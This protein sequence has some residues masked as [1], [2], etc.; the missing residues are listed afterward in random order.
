MAKFCTECGSRLEDNDIFCT[1]CGTKQAPLDPIPEPITPAA[2]PTENVPPQF[3]QQAP[4]GPAPVYA[5]PRPR[6]RVNLLFVLLGVILAAVIA[7]LAIFGSAAIRSSNYEK[8]FGQHLDNRFS[9]MGFT[10]DIYRFSDNLTASYTDMQAGIMQNDVRP[11]VLSLALE[12]STEEENT[13]F[14]KTY[15]LKIG[16]ELRTIANTYADFS[17]TTKYRDPVD[18][19]VELQTAYGSFIYEQSS[20]KIYYPEAYG[21]L[22]QMAQCFDTADPAQVEKSLSGKDWLLYNN[23]AS[24]KNGTF[25]NNA[26]TLLAQR[27]SPSV[28]IDR[29]GLFDCQLG[30]LSAKLKKASDS[31]VL[32]FDDVPSDAWYYKDVKTTVSLGLINGK[33]STTFAPDDRMTYAEIVKLAACINQL[34]YDGV[35]TL[36]N[37]EPWY[38]SYVDYCVQNGIISKTY[39][40]TNHAKRGDCLEILSKAIPEFAL[41]EINSIPDNYIVDVPASHP[42]AKAIYTLYRAG[43]MQGVDKR[44]RCKPSFYSD[45]KEIATF[46]VRMLDQSRRKHFDITSAPGSDIPWLGGN[47][48]ILD[49]RM[50]SFKAELGCTSY[51]ASKLASLGLDYICGVDDNLFISTATKEVFGAINGSVVLY[52]AYGLSGRTVEYYLNENILDVYPAIY[53]PPTE[54]SRLYLWKLSNGYL[55]AEVSNQANVAFYNQNVYSVVH[56]SNLSD[57]YYD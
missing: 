7:F 37:G 17:A 36:K 4:A 48:L 1:S 25:V 54:S 55:V 46:A 18:L 16:E 50:D 5:P 20:D 19:Y 38:Q 28:G 11:I 26:E 6:P 56:V 42:Q 3:T 47:S 30:S 10:T 51:A 44:H 27:T 8:A 52:A 43:V 29:L 53:Q 40:W 21:L 49:E 34:Y 35:V 15:L 22:H 9:T 14:W 13:A 23:L 31:V 32:K 2:A 33:T 57:L 41:E 45:R 24:N 12:A 39:K